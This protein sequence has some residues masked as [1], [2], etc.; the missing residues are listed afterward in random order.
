MGLMMVSMVRRDRI[1]G[2]LAITLFS[3]FLA[4]FFLKFLF[5]LPSG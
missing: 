3:C 5:F 1:D 2:K 4:L